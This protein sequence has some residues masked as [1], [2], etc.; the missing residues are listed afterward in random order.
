MTTVVVASAAP[1]PR[2]IVDAR[3]VRRRR[4]SAS[5]SGAHDTE[6]GKYQLIAGL[7][8]GGMADVY[9][10][11]IH[12]PE[13][14]G[15]S[16]LLVIKRLRPN[17]VE[18]PEFVAMLV[19]EARIAARLNHPNT[20]NTLEI[21]EV[22]G[23]YFIAM[24]YLDGQPLHRLL[25]RG[26]AAGDPMP[27]EHQLTVLA[28]TLAGLHHAHELLDYDGQSLGVV[29]RDV[30]PHNIFVLYSGQTKV[31]DFGIAKAAGR[32]SETKQGVV[33]GKMTYMAP[34]QAKGSADID[35][36]ADVFAVGIILW[37]ALTDSRMWKDLD[38]LTILGKLLDNDYEASPKAVNPEVPDELDAICRKALAHR[39]DDR[40]ATAEEFAEALLGYLRSTG[41]RPTAKELGDHV[42]ML[43]ADK[44]Q[45]TKSVIEAQL[46]Q[47]KRGE[48]RMLS[49]STAV[50]TPARLPSP[51][52]TNSDEPSLLLT[53]EEEPGPTRI[54]QPPGSGRRTLWIA[55]AIAA[56]VV[57]GGVVLRMRVE[58]TPEVSTPEPSTPT[59][60][61]SLAPEPS[62]P[63]SD[64]P[65]A[66][67]ASA[68]PKP[69]A[70]AINKRS[71]PVPRPSTAIVA[72]SVPVAT[73]P[74]DTGKKPP[75]PIDTVVP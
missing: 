11:A 6:F 18:D 71:P 31:V 33:K 41:K 46:A 62:A 57:V 40:Y 39:P 44:R 35:R 2:E 30:S 3:V 22:D 34:E 1:D 32:A 42:A 50:V 64:V 13:G 43:F 53:V 63:A 4:M 66:P 36:R 68:E 59:V 10:A 37:E 5:M 14:L 45:Q 67:A 48:L 28:E 74:A 27:L 7:G 61:P 51:A 49:I 29:H 55:A 60:V 19:D 70:S 73:P 69:I 24:E 20:V 58:P 47:L 23:Q 26:R 16:K 54:L 12:G 65:P 38:E 25:N 15:F 9:L 72:S 56:L 8:H 17:L 21:G 75:R 52:V